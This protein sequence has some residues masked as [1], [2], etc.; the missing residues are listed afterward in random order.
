MKYWMQKM[1][2]EVRK[3]V[4]VLGPQVLL[5]AVPYCAGSLFDDYWHPLATTI[6]WIFPPAR[7]NQTATAVAKALHEGAK[8]GSPSREA[9]LYAV[10]SDTV[11]VYHHC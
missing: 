8:W 10:V 4:R 6:S 11:G 3:R 9:P 5:Q 1:D 2:T 7:L